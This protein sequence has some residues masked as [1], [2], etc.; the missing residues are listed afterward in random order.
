MNEKAFSLALRRGL[1][2][3]I[4]ELKNAED[5]SAYREAVLRCCLRDITFDW[6]VEGS[7]GEYLYDAILAS[8]EPE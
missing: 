8:G 6:Q 1:G 2:G 4:V 5:K 3:A 7:K